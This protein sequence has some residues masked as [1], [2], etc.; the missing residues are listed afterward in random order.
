MTTEH[1][2]WAKKVFVVPRGIPRRVELYGG[3][4]GS[5]SYS[6][7]GGSTTKYILRTSQFPSSVANGEEYSEG[8]TSSTSAEEVV[9]KTFYYSHATVGKMIVRG[10][11]DVDAAVSLK[12]SDSSATAT[13]SSVVIKFGILRSNGVGEEIF[14]KTLTTNLTSTSTSYEDYSV[15]VTGEVDDIYTVEEGDVPYITVTLYGKIS[16]GA[17]TGYFKL[18]YGYATSNLRVEI[19]VLE[20]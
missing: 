19:P 2:D 5:D 20:A 6:I 4:L 12:T 1:L 7:P 17:Q 16:D 11:V 9:S 13:L 3:H 8:T 10:T 15:V 14:S 18:R